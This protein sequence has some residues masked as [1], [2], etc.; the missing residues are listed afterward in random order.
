MS[1]RRAIEANPPDRF[2]RRARV[3]ALF[4]AAAFLPRGVAVAEPAS[5]SS[6]WIRDFQFDPADPCGASVASG[7]SRGTV[8]ALPSIEVAPARVG[9]ALVRASVP[10]A[11]AALPEGLGIE[12]RVE[13]GGSGDAVAASVIAD[14]RPLTFH[15]GTPRSVR[16]AFVTFVHDFADLAPRRVEL[17]LAE[18]RSDHDTALYAAGARGEVVALE[19]DSEGAV[20]RAWNGRRARLS[21]EGASLLSSDGAPI[22]TA[23]AI[24]PGASPTAL[25]GEVIEASDSYLW[26]RLLADDPAWP[27]IVELRLDALGRA[28][29]E[30]AWQRIGDGDATAPDLGWEIGGARWVHDPAGP[31][32]A[33]SDPAGLVVRSADGALAADF[34]EAARDLRGRVEIAETGALRFFRCL[35][36]EAVPFQSRA[37]RRAAIRIAPDLDASSGA[38]DIEVRIAPE[39]FDAAY[40]RGVAPDLSTWPLLQELDRYTRDALVASACVGDDAGNVT[41]YNRGA[42]RAGAYGMNRLNHCPA[43]FEHG[44]R[45][46][47][48][49]LPRLG[50]D[51]CRNM[52][53]L[54]IWW[55]E[56]GFGGTR[57]NNAVAAGDRTHEGDANFMWRTNGDS[58]FCTKGYDAFLLAWEETGEPWALAALRAQVAYAREHVH[59]DR[60]EMRNIGDV[61]DF[62][63]LHRW[64]GRAE[65]LDEAT[66][67]F[68]QLRSKLST[69][70][71]FSQGGQPLEPES[72]HPFLDDDQVGYAHPFKKPYILGYALTGLPDLLRAKPD[73]PKLRDVVR[74]VADFLA[75]TVDPAGG[76]R[77]PHP[78][79]TATLIGQ[80]IEHAAQ[81]ANAAEILEARGEPIGNLLDA[82]ETVLRARVMGFER[83]GTILSGLGGWE[84]AT[85]SI[86][87]G[88][89][90]ELYARP[91]DR[92]ASRA[93]DYAE[94]NAGAGSAPPDG[95]AHWDRAL[96]FYLERRPAERLFHAGPELRQV[97]ERLPARADDGRNGRDGRN[98]PDGRNQVEEA[99]PSGPSSPSGPSGVP[100][101]RADLPSFAAD[102]I[103][104]MTFPLSRESSRDA[105]FDAWRARARAALL[106]SLGDPPPRATFAPE[107]L[108]VQRRDGYEARRI[109]FNVSGDCRVPAYLLVPDGAPRGLPAVLA[110]HD[111]GAR[112][113]IGKEKVVRPFGEGARGGVLEDA[114]AWV[115]ECYGGRWFGDELARRG[116][117]VLAVDALYWGERGRAER[118]EAMPVDDDADETS[119]HP[120]L[121]PARAMELARA[122]Y[123]HQ[124]ALGANL[125]QLG[126]SWAGV[127]LWDDLRSA[128]F[129]RSLPEVDPARVGAMGLS[130]GAF[131]AWNLSA[132]TD[133]IRAAAAICWMGDTPTLS[134]PGNNQTR[135]Q[136]AFSML[137]PGI[138]R[139]LD[140]PDVASIAAPKPAL[141]FHGTRDPLFPNEGV[142]ACYAK[143]RATW[144]DGTG[145]RLSAT[146]EAGSGRSDA[147]DGNGGSRLV[148]R[149]W[150]RPH[151]FDV[152]MQDAAIDW[153]A[154]ELAA[155]GFDRP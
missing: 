103:A 1:R 36:S 112:F 155:P 65:H 116:F 6:D 105:P 125:L 133:S 111:H 7:V 49:R 19:A 121:D 141:F 132:A 33:S 89:V 102:R 59:C 21:A 143:L 45:S 8:G 30:I 23:R 11:P 25:R 138:R 13:A 52:H 67:L 22:W 77:Y 91:E 90:G 34:P 44:L 135:G 40:G 29:L 71:L 109:V 92:D 142:E 3:V 43:I 83:T 154:R 115:E 110:L 150:G 12:A 70:D 114:R 129:L 96:S 48:A 37:W 140:Y 28:R 17:S 72:E 87:E 126:M 53:D 117:V 78:R 128:E 38:G 127:I 15:P 76:W 5:G 42:A 47:D 68:A 88:G 63:R 113:S 18:A 139:L 24:G 54:S 145:A 122:D 120:P 58:N 20:E 16:R 84:A 95:L 98:G 108:E 10:F 118:L 74:A 104:R 27:R 80:G 94:G 32:P 97:L 123:E 134:S 136:S 101:V 66:R 41:G 79:S 107:V 50:A 75:A 73:E 153:M 14:V 35:A 86:P 60:G 31:D 137:Q 56:K 55:G 46:G 144:A 85:G 9:R 151:V 131:R 106:D 149:A 93:R 124:Q 39:A 62:M 152:E 146:R 61:S 51:W 82:I 119:A 69:D 81:I 4:L 147:D 99:G 148:T 64:T 26:M 130:M 2:G 100:G 57:Y